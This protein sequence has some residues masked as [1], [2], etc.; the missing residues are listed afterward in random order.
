MR[1][2]TEQDKTKEKKMKKTFLKTKTNNKNIF[3]Q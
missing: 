3:G 1:S 2:T